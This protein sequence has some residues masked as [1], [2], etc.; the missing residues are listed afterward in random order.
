MKVFYIKRRDDTLHQSWRCRI[1][2]NPASIGAAPRT[3]ESALKVD[4]Q[5]VELVH[6]NFIWCNT[7]EAKSEDGKCNEGAN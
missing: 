6:P 1:A 4:H 5:Q 3:R 7:D 2:T